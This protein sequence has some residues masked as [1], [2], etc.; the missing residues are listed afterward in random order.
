MRA[1]RRKPKSHISPNSIRY[2]SQSHKKTRVPSVF[3]RKRR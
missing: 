3:Y 1:K 2:S